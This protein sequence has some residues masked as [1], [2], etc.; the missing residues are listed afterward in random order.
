MGNFR[1]I[2]VDSPPP[3]NVSRDPS[4]Y[5]CQ[6]DPELGGIKQPAMEQSSGSPRVK[7]PRVVICLVSTL[8]TIPENVTD[9]DALGYQRLQLK[10]LRLSSTLAQNSP[11]KASKLLNEYQAQLQGGL[12][13]LRRVILKNEKALREKSQ[14]RPKE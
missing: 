5:R 12:E 14:P 4:S 6:P 13:E 9:S 7:R 3:T 1:P 11:D 10:L 8:E 2:G